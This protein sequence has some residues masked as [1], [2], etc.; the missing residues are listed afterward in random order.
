MDRR[1]FLIGTGSILS[2]AFV[3]KANWFLRNQNSVVPFFE[4]IEPAQKLHFV[5]QQDDWYNIFLNKSD[6]CF[7]E[8]TY[9]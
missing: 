5:K 4:N 6:Y 9:R 7:P 3:D 2:T 1:S 8:L